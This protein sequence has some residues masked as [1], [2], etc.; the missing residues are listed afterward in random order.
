DEPEIHQN[1]G[2]YD[3]LLDHAEEVAAAAVESGHFAFA[4]GLL[5]QHHGVFRIAGIC[6]GKGF[7][8]RSPETAPRMRLRVIGRSFMRRPIALK[9]ALPTAATAGTLLDSPML[10]DPNAP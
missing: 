6:A 8:T 5:G 9:I 3:S 1:I 4:S 10:F 7:H 2:R